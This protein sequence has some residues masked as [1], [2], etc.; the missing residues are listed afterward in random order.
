VSALRF[1]LVRHGR[2]EPKHR[3]GDAARRLTPEGRTRF[4][5]HARAL[6]PDLEVSRIVTSPFARARETA[7]LLAR[8]T[9]APVD[10]DAALASGA[11]SGAELLRLGAALGAG[12]ALV[13]HNPELA[14]A[15]AAAA[16]TPV[17]FPPGAIAAVDADGSGFRLA[18][19]RAPA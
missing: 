5:E 16:R 13:G 6:A 1:Y 10:E 11:S 8:A 3:C 15:I 7:D 12:A 9:P 17:D 2:A 4:A 18:W 14:E 19:L